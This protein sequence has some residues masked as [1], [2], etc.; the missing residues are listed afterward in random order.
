MQLLEVDEPLGEVVERVELWLAF[1]RRAYLLLHDVVVVLVVADSLSRVEV[2]LNHVELDQAGNR[3]L[4]VAA[5]VE[6]HG[7]HAV[8]V[9]L[10]RV[11]L[12]PV[13]SSLPLL[14]LAGLQM[15]GL[16]LFRQGLERAY[17]CLLGL[18]EL[19]WLS[20]RICAVLVGSN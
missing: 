12:P 20:L 11:G 16:R 18:D 5:L 2:T 17:Q 4:L 1:A 8:D 6:R 13:L 10:Q 3:H 7:L 9:A 15:V 19:L 14:A